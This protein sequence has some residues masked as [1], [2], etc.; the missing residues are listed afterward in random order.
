MRRCPA[1][2]LWTFL[3]AKGIIIGQKL[4]NNG[5]G[6]I[7]SHAQ[8]DDGK[9]SIVPPEKMFM[10]LK[11]DWIGKIYASQYIPQALEYARLI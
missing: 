4:K 6:N 3:P 10:S 2:P 5:G 8:H 1:S 7:W 11:S 9:F